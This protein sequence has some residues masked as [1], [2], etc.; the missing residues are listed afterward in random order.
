MFL[1]SIILDRLPL[2]LPPK[3]TL[4]LEASKDDRVAGKE[5]LL[6]TMLLLAVWSILFGVYVSGEEQRGKMKNKSVE[7]QGEMHPRC[8][9]NRQD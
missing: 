5:Y 3:V 8:W 1:Q 4:C 9:E 7:I 6:R 2:V